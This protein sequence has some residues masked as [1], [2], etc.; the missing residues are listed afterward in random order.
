MIPQI[1]VFSNVDGVLHDPPVHAFGAAAR[2]LRAL[3]DRGIPLILSS[4]K[5]RAE[6]ASV[7]QELG[8]RH[9]FSCE[10]GA[11][12]FI[13]HDYFSAD[14]PHA[15]LVGGH[16]A[17]EFGRTYAEVVEVLHRTAANLRIEIAGF[18]DMSVEDVAREC[19]LTLLRARLAKLRE[20]DEP[21]RTLDPDPRAHSRLVRALHAARLRCVR[22][23][24]FD[25]A[26]AAV[27]KRVV[28]NVLWTLYQRTRD[29]LVTI[30]LDDPLSDDSL[31]NLADY[32]VSAPEAAASQ[33]DLVD[34]ARTIA[35]VVSEIDRAWTAPGGAH[36]ELWRVRRLGGRERRKRQRVLG[37]FNQN[38]R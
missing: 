16:L 29:R 18:S 22:I 4:N 12:L 30:A 38:S 34:W 33:V 3:T 21:F 20:Y 8:L 23:G 28:L 15:R 26:G 32:A 19:R 9:P 17:V 7:Q 25:H 31:L 36:H 13:P 1:L 11:A 10:R 2:I 14:V 6:L 5:T 24:A 37:P 27:N 35:D